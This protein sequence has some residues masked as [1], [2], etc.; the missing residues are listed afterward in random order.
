MRYLTIIIM[1]LSSLL[2]AASC[3]TKSDQPEEPKVED[4]ASLDNLD[5]GIFIAQDDSIP[6]DPEP[7]SSDDTP[8]EVPQDDPEPATDDDPL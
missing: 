8:D 2:M 3:E 4:E 5:E 6:D 1:L 7:V